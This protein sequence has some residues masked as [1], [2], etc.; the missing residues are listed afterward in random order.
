MNIVERKIIFA[1]REW[2]LCNQRVLYWNQKETLILSDLHVGKA[3]HFRRN[4]IAIPTDIARHDLVRL[5]KLIHHYNAKKALVVGDLIHAGFNSKV[6]DFKDF[7]ANF[8]GVEFVLVKG[9]H[10]RLSAKKLRAL[11]IVEFYTVLEIDDITF[12]HQSTKQ[13]DVFEITGHDHPG[14]RLKMPTRGYLKLPCFVVSERTLVLPAV[15]H[16]T[17]LNTSPVS[18]KVVRYGVAEEGIFEIL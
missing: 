14:V 3:N 9:N 16:F 4:G 10:D 13:P 8:A 18:N 12:S 2:T 7:I 11:D 5:E 1:E 17:G 15:S 6:L